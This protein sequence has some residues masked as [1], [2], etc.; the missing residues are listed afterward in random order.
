MGIAVTNTPDVLTEATAELTWA[1]ILS[2]ARHIPEAHRYTREERFRGWD[3]MLFLGVE[4]WG[5][6]L[7][8]VGTGRIGTAVAFKAPAFGMSVLYHDKTPNPR[9]EKEVGALKVDLKTLLSR[10]DVITLHVPLTDETK[11]LIGKEELTLM[12]RSAILINTSR[13]PVVDERALIWALKERRIFSAGLDVYEREPKVPK[14]LLELNNV[15]TLPHI[16]SATFEARRKMAILAARNVVEALSGRVPPNL[17]NREV[18][19]KWRGSS[20]NK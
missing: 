9:L 10:S 7:G 18:I 3:P 19:P 20:L 4:L 14:E 17:V 6:T 16:G 8:V 2:A 13:G 12:K 5:K 1:L 11:G 15:T